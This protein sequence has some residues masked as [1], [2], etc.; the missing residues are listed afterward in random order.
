MQNEVVHALERMALKGQTESMYALL[1]AYAQILQKKQI[2]KTAAEAP[3]R[4]EKGEWLGHDE[5]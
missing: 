2:E 4:N 5:Q 3:R 1:G